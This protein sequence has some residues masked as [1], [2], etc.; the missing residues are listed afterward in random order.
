VRSTRKVEL[1]EAGRI[2]LWDASALA[3]AARAA[4]RSAQML[5]NRQSGRISIGVPPY[6][7]SLEAKTLLVKKFIEVRP[8]ASVELDVGWSRNLLDRLLNHT[9]DLA[10]ILDFAPQPALEAVTLGMYQSVLAIRSDEAIAQREN[11]RLEHF[12]GREIAV[13]TRGL[14]PSLYDK[15]YGPL[16][17]AGAKLLQVTEFA[18]LDVDR[19]MNQPY[20]MFTTLAWHGSSPVDNPRIVIRRLVDYGPQVPMMLVRRKEWSG[21]L[22]DEFWQLANDGGGGAGPA[23]VSS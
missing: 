6:H 18:D 19:G 11:L 12:S 17:Q 22:Q 7:A 15:L 8:K 2:F 10:F 13:F 5:Q 4:E 21:K 9:V 14:N 3:Q 1:T 20:P 23:L 16:E